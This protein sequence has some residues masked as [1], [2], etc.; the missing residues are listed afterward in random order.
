MA[1]N[2]HSPCP[3]IATNCTHGDQ[4]SQDVIPCTPPVEASRPT[5]LMRP[6]EAIL[7]RNQSSWNH[8]S[9]PGSQD[10]NTSVLSVPS[11]TTYL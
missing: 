11:L 1:W 6:S 10:V 4:V 2:F 7:S 8:Q 3:K 9:M 5:R